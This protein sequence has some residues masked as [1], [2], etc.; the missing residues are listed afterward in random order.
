MGLHKKQGS[1]AP[2][3]EE[4]R[5]LSIKASL[6]Q[7]GKVPLNISLWQAWHYAFLDP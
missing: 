4:W 7:Q 6:A 2:G 5:V 3:S 1:V